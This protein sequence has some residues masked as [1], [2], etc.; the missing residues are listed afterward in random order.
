M[1]Y[2]ATVVGMV[3]VIALMLN[4]ANS[5]LKN[6]VGVCCGYTNKWKIKTLEKITRLENQLAV[7][8]DFRKRN[9]IT[10]ESSGWCINKYHRELAKQ[11]DKVVCKNIFNNAV[12][13]GLLWAGCGVENI[14]VCMNENRSAIDDMV[15]HAFNGDEV[16]Y[17]SVLFNLLKTMERSKCNVDDFAREHDNVCNGKHKNRN[18]YRVTRTA[19]KQRVNYGI[20]RQDSKHE[21]VDTKG[22]VICVNK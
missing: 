13:M 22:G 18:K 8:G 11:M 21:N 2:L 10:I 20:V 7:N 16:D 12:R 15:N 5:F 17:G 19:K 6:T 14:E 9:D 4:M 3:S 1:F